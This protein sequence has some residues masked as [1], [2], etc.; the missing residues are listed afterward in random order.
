MLQFLN[1]SFSEQRRD[2]LGC[3]YYWSRLALLDNEIASASS[4]VATWEMSIAMAR[5]LKI[6]MEVLGQHCYV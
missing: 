5:L 2:A 6:P 1:V 4:F 3:C